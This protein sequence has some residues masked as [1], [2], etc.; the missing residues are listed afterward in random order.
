MFQTMYIMHNIFV[1]IHGTVSYLL[2]GML[3]FRNKEAVF[4]HGTAAVADPGGDGGGLL[5]IPLLKLSNKAR[6]TGPRVL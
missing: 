2:N 5:P 6:H 4:A 1:L 3:T